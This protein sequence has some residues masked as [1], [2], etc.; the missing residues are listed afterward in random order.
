VVFAYFN[1]WLMGRRWDVSQRADGGAVGPGDDV[2]VAIGV[3]DVVGADA[4]VVFE[5][6]DFATFVLEKIFHVII[7]VIFG[8]YFGNRVLGDA[9]GGHQ[10]D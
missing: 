3:I 6:V 5:A 8:R 10:A 4:V 2:A 7:F 1:P 9:C